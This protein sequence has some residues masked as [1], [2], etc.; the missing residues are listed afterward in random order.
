MRS[1]FR[2][3]CVTWLQV[4]STLDFPAP[5]KGPWLFFSMWVLMLLSRLAATSSNDLMLSRRCSFFFSKAATCR[6]KCTAAFSASMS[7]ASRFPV[8]YS[9]LWSAMMISSVATSL[10]K[11]RSCETHSSVPLYS[12]TRW[13]CSQATPWRSKWLVGSSSNRHVGLAKSAAASAARICQPLL[14]L[15]CGVSITS[16]SKPRPR[17]MPAARPRRAPSLSSS[18]AL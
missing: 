15:P 7:K 6:S 4:L 1:S 12:C 5:W 3:R 8:K 14:R 16:G 9:R 13:C 17:R 18:R 10:M 11:E 2:S